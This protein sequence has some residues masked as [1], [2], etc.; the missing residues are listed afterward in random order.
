MQGLET[1]KPP[2]A[3]VFE[4][5]FKDNKLRDLD[6]LSPVVKFI[7]DTM[8]E[9]GMI[10]EDHYRVVTAV[11]MRVGKRRDGTIDVTVHNV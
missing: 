10:P 1:F 8:V 3:T 7:H 2:V 9:L 4:F 6:N 11:S 5:N